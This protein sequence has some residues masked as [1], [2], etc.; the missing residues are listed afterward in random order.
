MVSSAYLRFLIFLLAILIP[1]GALSSLAF[2][3][4]YFAYKLYKQGDDIQSLGG[5]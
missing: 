1:A 3:M 2:H 4:M 5:G